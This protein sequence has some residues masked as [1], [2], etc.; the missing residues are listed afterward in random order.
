MLVP[1]LDGKAV[2]TVEGL[3]DTHGGLDAVQQVIVDAHGTQCG[4][5]TPGFVMALYAF[6]QSGEPVELETIHDV[7]AGNLCRCTGYRPIVDAAMNL[8]APPLGQLA[9]ELS[10]AL[11]SLETSETY[12]RKGERFHAPKS[13]DRL[14]MLR[15]DHPEARL[16]GGGT[17]LGIL[18]SKDRHRFGDII[19]TGAVD[20]L[21]RIE[22]DDHAVTIPP[23][24]T[25][26]PR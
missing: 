1:Q 10:Q 20:E 7:L 24:Q 26:N 12:E 5:C 19:W 21:R 11:A 15:A 8:T 23:S 22:R 9:K 18:A 16:L 13:L 25:G 14:L 2:V 3:S 17:D 6:H 4:F